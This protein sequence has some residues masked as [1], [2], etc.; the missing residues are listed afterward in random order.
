MKVHKNLSIS[1]KFLIGRIQ[2]DLGGGER[3]QFKA[4]A[5]RYFVGDLL[6]V[7]GDKIELGVVL[8]AIVQIAEADDFGLL[9]IY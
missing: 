2:E 5:S 8:L 4:L 7:V 9:S 6:E 3:R 1:A